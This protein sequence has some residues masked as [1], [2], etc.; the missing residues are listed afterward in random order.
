LE[1]NPDLL[2]YCNGVDYEAQHDIGTVTENGVGVAG[3]QVSAGGKTAVTDGNGDYTIPDMHNG[4]YSVSCARD[5]NG[6]GYEDFI[7]NPT[8]QTV[9]VDGANV[10]GVNFTA[11]PRTYTV[12]G[13]ITDSAGNRVANVT[14]SD[15]THTTQTDAAG[16]YTLANVPASTVTITPTR[17]GMAFS[18]VDA[19]VTVP[20]SATDVNFTAYEE[21]THRFPAGKSMVAL[22]LTPPPGQRRLVDI[23]GTTQVARWD[24]SA[25]PPAYV[26]GATDP[27][28][29][30]LQARPGAA[31]FVNLPLARNITVAGDPVM[32]VGSFSV[33]LP[34]G[35]NM[36]GNM[37]QTA[38]PLANMNAAG[39]G[40]LRPFAFVYDN[41]TNGYLMVSRDPALNAVRNFLQAWEGAWFRAV[42]TN[43]SVIVTAP[44]G[45]AT[46]ALKDGSEAQAEAPE[47]GWLIPIVARAAGA[48][49][50]CTLAGV[51]NGSES[52]G[53]RVE[54]P[55]AL[56]GSVDVY[57]TDASG[58]R[59][60]HDVRPLGTANT[61]WNFVVETD[62]S[63][64]RV[65]LTL[66]DLSGVPSDQAVYLTD[67]DTGKKLYARTMPSYSFTAG[68]GGAQRHFEL[69]V[70]PKGAD[71]LVITSASVQPTGA[72]AVVTYSVSRPCQVSV[73]V[74]NIAG[75]PVRSLVTG[76]PAPAGS[77]VQTWDLRSDD[78]TLAPSGQYLV[79][80]EAVADNGQ[81][82]Q[83]LR[84]LHVAR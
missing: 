83:A 78:G 21:F 57:F 69:T 12:Q 60:A 45:T 8:S 41:A 55:P 72:G 25:N 75:R 64:A 48:T 71:N 82:V 74:L 73:E 33:G 79:R 66:P 28:H 16:R 2:I 31:Y 29:L 4:I 18:P 13:V 84:P 10:A 11:T 44:S 37:Y 14:V 51:G 34:D 49:D 32:N 26:T 52:A 76:A 30:Q 59:L 77:N 62:I 27:D 23:F 67:L 24:A 9:N 6:D 3:V 46:A 81:R 40:Q 53:Y 56:P 36:V 7:Y 47:G 22:P 38:L 61:T 50:R 35:W 1:I 68:A 20:P 17:T 19:Q 58:A 80:I 70:Q 43:V 15:G 5:A 54:N 63:E 65:E 42:G 39:G